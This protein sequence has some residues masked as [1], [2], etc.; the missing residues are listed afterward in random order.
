MNTPTP[1]SLKPTLVPPGIHPG[2]GKLVT[3]KGVFRAKLRPELTKARVEHADYR[4]T[5]FLDGGKRASALLWVHAD[6]TL[7]LRIQ[8]E[9]PKPTTL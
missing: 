9:T 6:G 1:N 3:Q 2:P 4:G 5:I 8:L 7:G